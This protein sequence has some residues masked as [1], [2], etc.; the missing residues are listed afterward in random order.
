MQDG[1]PGNAVEAS[2]LSGS[3]SVICLQI[4]VY[5]SQGKE[6]CQKPGLTEAKHQDA[7]K[8]AEQVG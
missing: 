7:A 8:E 6:G 5:N 1:A 3:V 4:L 2:E